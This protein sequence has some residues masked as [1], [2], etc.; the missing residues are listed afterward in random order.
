MRYLT[1]GWR[2]KKRGAETSV[3]VSGG[4]HTVVSPYIYIC[5]DR[6]AN[7]I[8]YIQRRNAR[9]SLFLFLSFSLCFPVFSLLENCINLCHSTLKLKSNSR[10]F[11]YMRIFHQWRKVLHGTFTHNGT[12]F[13]G[14]LRPRGTCAADIRS[15]TS[16]DQRRQRVITILSCMQFSLRA[17][18]I[19]ISNR[20]KRQ[21]GR[22][23]FWYSFHFNNV[24][25]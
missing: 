7:L 17:P 9:Y 22:S 10:S 4:Q 8:V 18:I 16:C 15:R 21:I 19:I 12:L 25:T 24:L 23:I 11:L 3:L 20:V 14:D 5:D 2:D 6:H 1:D 13:N